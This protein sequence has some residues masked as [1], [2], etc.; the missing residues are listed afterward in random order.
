MRRL[1]I[2]FLLLLA[3]VLPSCAA[4]SL[5][6]PAAEWVQASRAVHD[7]I[8]PRFAAYVEADADLEEVERAQLLG[9]VGD[10]ELMVRTAEDAIAD[11]GGGE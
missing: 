8:A 4:G 5:S 11:D 1:P 3:A 2:L 9:L 6:N 7:V 10:W